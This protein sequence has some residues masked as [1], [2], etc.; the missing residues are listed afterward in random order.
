M[1]VRFVSARLNGLLQGIVYNDDNTSILF[2]FSVMLKQ[3]K[4]IP[5]VTFL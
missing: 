4:I 1:S 2:T 3:I 5:F